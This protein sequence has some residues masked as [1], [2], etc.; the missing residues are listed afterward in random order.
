MLRYT[1]RR[2]QPTCV[3]PLLDILHKVER[4]PVSGRRKRAEHLKGEKDA[5]RNSQKRGMETSSKI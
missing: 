4:V 3:W 2:Q 1:G 5:L